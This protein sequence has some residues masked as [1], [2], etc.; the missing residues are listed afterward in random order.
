MTVPLI[1]AE[2]CKQHCL[3]KILSITRLFI[4]LYFIIKDN[5]N[6]EQIKKA[7]HLQDTS[8]ILNEGAAF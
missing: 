4:S 6:I 5:P 2:D 1:S 7:S 3:P 8:A